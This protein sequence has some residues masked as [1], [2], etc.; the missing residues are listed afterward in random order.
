[1]QKT[2]S[3]FLAAAFILAGLTCQKKPESVA[4][5]NAIAASTGK[6]VLIEVLAD[7]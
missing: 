5:A 1:M 2:L 4:E 3:L 6:P 7:W